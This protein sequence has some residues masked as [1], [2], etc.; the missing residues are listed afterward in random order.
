MAAPG[1]RTWR[2]QLC[3]AT[4]SF[5]CFIHVC[6]CGH[7]QEL[8]GFP[9]TETESDREEGRQEGKRGPLRRP[10]PPNTGAGEAASERRQPA[11]RTRTED[12]RS[13]GALSRRLPAQSSGT[14][15]RGQVPV[16]ERTGEN[17]HGLRGARMHSLTRLALVPR[18]RKH[19]VTMRTD[20]SHYEYCFQREA[21]HGIT[22]STRGPPLV[23]TTAVARGWAGHDWAWGI[24]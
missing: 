20:T 18:A 10:P 21:I 19:Q 5:L 2:H 7:T 3:Y 15:R 12:P 24:H 9:E 14:V 6:A 1:G 22:T 13:R 17:K 23:R 8:S 11:A 4:L 16:T